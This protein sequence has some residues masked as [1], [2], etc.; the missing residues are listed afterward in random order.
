MDEFHIRQKIKAHI[1]G[2]IDE[3]FDGYFCMYKDN[4]GFLLFYHLLAV[5]KEFIDSYP[6]QG[7]VE[8]YRSAVSWFIN[9][10]I[11]NLKNIHLDFVFNSDDFD[12]Y[13]NN[14]LPKIYKAYSDF[15]F[16]NEIMDMH[17]F[18]KSRLTE[19]NKGVYKLTSSTVWGGFIKEYL[20]YNG[21][22]DE[23]TMIRERK[24]KSRPVLY[25]AKKINDSK[26]K[27]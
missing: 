12:Y 11:S 24:M 5:E 9:R 25:I 7:N 14:I 3:F 2:Q 19:V 16:L 8:F 21:I 23:E 26:E 18:V 27:N 6:N 13:C 22:H 20:Y 10:S 4:I 15:K 17:S 1:E